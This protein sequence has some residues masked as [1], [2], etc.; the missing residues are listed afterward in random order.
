MTS[1]P[2]AWNKG[3]SPGPSFN[4]FIQTNLFRSKLLFLNIF[5][6]VIA[7]SSD[8]LPLSNKEASMETLIRE[9]RDD[10]GDKE[11]SFCFFF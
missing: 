2:S 1:P 7:T 4:K 9:K 5:L 10:F 11:V 6:I 8:G 3:V